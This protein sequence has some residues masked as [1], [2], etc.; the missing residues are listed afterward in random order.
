[1][2]N[3]YYNHQ[4]GMPEFRVGP[5]GIL[6]TIIVLLISV[7]VLLI[8]IFVKATMFVAN[9]LFCPGGIDNKVITK[10]KLTAHTAPLERR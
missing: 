1:M 5:L 8:G 10:K 7:V 4:T 6:L 2:A 9:A 3:I